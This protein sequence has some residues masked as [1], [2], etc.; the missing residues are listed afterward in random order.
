MLEISIFGELY[1]YYS[2]TELPLFNDVSSQILWV[3][4][5]INGFNIALLLQV[6]DY[7]KGFFLFVFI[8]NKGSESVIPRIHMLVAAQYGSFDGKDRLVNLE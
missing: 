3:S 8:F 7:F 4:G 5:K 6:T 2:A 1:F